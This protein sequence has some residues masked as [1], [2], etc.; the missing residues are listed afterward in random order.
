MECPN[1][2]NAANCRY[3]SSLGKFLVRFYS[4]TAL[5]I[6]FYTSHRHA[7]FAFICWIVAFLFDV[8]TEVMVNG[9]DMFFAGLLTKKFI[10]LIQEAKDGTLDLNH[11][12][13]ILQVLNIVI[14]SM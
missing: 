6:W 9:F 7:Q 2:L 10:S 8:A 14:I 1:G 3:D 11:T 12:A 5:H 4:I 13:D